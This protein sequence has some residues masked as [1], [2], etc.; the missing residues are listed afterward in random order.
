MS[1]DT[2]Y[3]SMI[4]QMGL[5]PD[6]VPDDMKQT[7]LQKLGLSKHD[8]EKGNATKSKDRKVKSKGKKGRVSET[9]G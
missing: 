3:L 7:I 2:R 4:G 6:I 8:K 5:T 1:E 9:D